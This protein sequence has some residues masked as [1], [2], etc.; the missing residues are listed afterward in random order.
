MESCVN[1]AYGSVV[2]YDYVCTW[3]SGFV[4]S[5]G[6]STDLEEETPDDDG[7]GSW[8]RSVGYIVLGNGWEIGSEADA[9][10][11]FFAIPMAPQPRP[12]TREGLDYTLVRTDQGTAA[13]GIL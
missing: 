8:S 7:L 2:T 10:C 5:R 12:G 11:I 1:T 13:A 9:L 3:Q 4:V 6:G